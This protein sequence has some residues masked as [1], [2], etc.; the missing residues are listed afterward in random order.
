MHDGDSEDV[1][2]SNG[3]QC[4]EDNKEDENSPRRAFE[5]TQKRMPQTTRPESENYLLMTLHT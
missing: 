5:S 4:E 3:R 2:G 1:S